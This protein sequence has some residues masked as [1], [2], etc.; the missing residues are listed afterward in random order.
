MSITKILIVDGLSEGGLNKI[1]SIPGVEVV[2]KPAMDREEIKSLLGETEILIVRSRTQVDRDLLAGAKK[3]KLAIRAGIGLDNIDVAAAT[4]AGVVVMNAPTGNIVTTAEH[5]IAMLFAV[6][7]R[8]PQ[9]DASMRA[10]KWDKKSF[11]GNEI[12]NKTIG[13]VGFGNIGKAVAERARGLSM[14]VVAYDPYLTEEAAARHQVKLLSLDD[15]LATADY[16]TLHLPMMESTRN[17]IDEKAIQK[18]KKGAFLINCAR[19]GIVDESALARALESKHLAGAAL[20]VFE[21]EPLQLDSP[22]LKRPEVVLTPHLG[23]S[24]DEAQIQVGLE[25]AEQISQY[26]AE[27]ALKNAINVPNVSSE[28]M[29]VMRPYLAL[30]ERL[31]TFAGQATPASN[32]RK[33]SV[34]FAGIDE[35]YDRSVLTLSAL[36]GFLTA[37]LST[38]VNF[39]NARKLLRERGIEIEESVMDA[40]GNYTSLVEIRIDADQVYSYAGTIFGKSEP[41]IVA[42]DSFAIDARLGGC[43]LYTRNVDTPGVIGE[44]GSTLGKEGINIAR[45][46]LGRGEEAGEAIA[47]ISVDSELTPVQMDQVRSIKAMKSATQ[48]RV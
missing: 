45:M 18:M 40:T 29:D 21:K 12:R 27:G 11:Q 33:I 28:Q 14:K 25:V 20:D 47:L 2:A 13:I 1:K 31:G 23:A 38:P 36:K 16:V 17:L 19:G 34:R 46:H 32:V 10:G 44:M 5:A 35:K 43:M 37:Q 26:L 4:D 15:L 8:I 30:C 41:R 6:S 3:L 22:L 42:I 39:V 24:T 9:A 48:I 7:R